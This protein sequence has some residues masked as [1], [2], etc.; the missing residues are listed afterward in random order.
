MTTT[1]PELIRQSAAAL[2]YTLAVLDETGR[3][4][5]G[6][7]PGDA[8]GL[9]MTVDEAIALAP[10]LAHLVIG[11]RHALAERHGASGPAEQA[12]AVRTWLLAELE[13][14]ELNAAFADVEAEM[15][16]TRPTGR[17]G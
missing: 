11:A 12:A 15:K 2:R 3:Q 13:G 5:G 17:N 14:H 9:A 1:P 10:A 8:A 7:R 4:A 16:G 6:G